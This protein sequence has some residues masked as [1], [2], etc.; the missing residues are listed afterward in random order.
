MPKWL[1]KTLEQ[2]AHF[3]WAGGMVAAVLLI[4]QPWGGLV[5]ALI[6]ALPRELVDQWPI[7]RP[8]DTVLDTVMF[9]LGGFLVSLLVMLLR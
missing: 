1:E 3:A 6:L 8:W 7:N 2:V 9:A 4:P 5:G